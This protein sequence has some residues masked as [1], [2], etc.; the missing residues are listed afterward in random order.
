MK[1]TLLI[2]VL[3]GGGAERVCSN[4]ANFLLKQ[5]HEVDILM[6]SDEVTYF[7][8]GK[9]KIC[10]MTKSWTKK[11]PHILMNVYRIF[12]FN[13]YLRKQ[14]PDVY[15]TFLPELTTLLFRQRCFFK[16][17][18]VLAERNDPETFCKNSKKYNK[19][20]VKYFSKAQ[21]YVFQ[22][23][24]AKAY[25]G[26]R[27]INI[28][29]SIVIPN[30][31][32]PD[33][34]KPQYKGV[35]NKEV[36]GVGRLSPQKNFELLICA[37]ANI[38]EEIPEYTLTIYGKGPL[39]DKYKK[40]VRKMGLES[41]IFFAG[42]INNIQDVIQKASLFVLPSDFEGMPN[43]LAEAM[44]LGLPCISTD[45]PAGGA[46]FLINNGVN[47]LLVPINDVDALSSE[48]LRILRDKA[49]ATK[50]ANNSRAVVDKLGSEK[51]YTAWENFIIKTVEQNGEKN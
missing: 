10:S 38:A 32:N 28:K 6:T 21:G 18:I 42:Y 1:I 43:A 49:F 46:R 41:R 7:V 4:L 25:Y 19:L 31:I 24:E 33:F 47:G 48:M 37:F 50:L 14:K 36:I 12:Y 29:N 23:E 20:F 15:V 17:P 27:G 13:H 2:G 44:A 11:L 16:T 22:T 9:V 26:N 3:S 35:R 39:L 40:N 8:D 45:C 51:I 34:I 5:G 30:A